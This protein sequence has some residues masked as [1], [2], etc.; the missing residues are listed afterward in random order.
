MRRTNPLGTRHVVRANT[1]TVRGDER[2]KYQRYA[3]HSYA[4]GRACTD[5]LASETTGRVLAKTKTKTA[6]PPADPPPPKT[7]QP[8]PPP[9][10]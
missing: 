4:L 5:R 7:L 10:F 9:R 6:H 2:E 8:T 3:P 1:K